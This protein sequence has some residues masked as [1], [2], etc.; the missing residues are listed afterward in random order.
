MTGIFL[1]DLVL[2]GLATALFIAGLFVVSAWIIAALAKPAD[3]ARG[4]A[5][6]RAP[7]DV[8]PRRREAG[9]AGEPMHG[10]DDLSDIGGGNGGE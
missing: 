4:P 6:R 2:V 3:L 1:L 5:R 8:D 7:S 10:L 9:R